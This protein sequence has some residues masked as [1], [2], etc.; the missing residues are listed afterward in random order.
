[1]KDTSMLLSEER[2]AVAKYGLKMITSGLVKG[3]GGNISLCNADKTLLA[4]TPSGVPYEDI[5]P[6]DVVVVDMAGTR[7]DGRL[8]PS[9]EM[10]FHL[11]LIK[12]RSDIK[13]VVHT[14]SEYATVL[15]CLRWELPAVHY[16][17]GSAGGS[18]PLAHY[19]T[20]G[21][22]NLAENMCRVIGDRNAVLMANHG[23]AAVGINLRKA[24]NTA[25]LVEYVAKVYLLTKSVGLPVELSPDEIQEVIRRSAGY[26][27]QPGKTD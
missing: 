2:I 25:E 9:S 8:Q 17:L 1:M 18:V 6:E 5:G 16:L 27:E 4:I 11:A 21:T 22:H 24:F 13:A 19:A 14:H 3:T 7:V 12:H 20:F 26:G 15:S 23:L 10:A